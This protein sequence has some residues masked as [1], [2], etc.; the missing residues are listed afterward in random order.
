MAGWSRRKRQPRRRQVREYK[1]VDTINGDVSHS[2]ARMRS[3]EKNMK[4]ET[5]R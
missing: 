1:Y 4:M 5:S 3:L 2:K